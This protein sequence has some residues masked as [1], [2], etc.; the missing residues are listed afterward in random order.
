MIGAFLSYLGGRTEV[1]IGNNDGVVFTGIGAVGYRKRFDASAIKDVRIDD[2]QWRG[3]DGYRRRKECIV[4]ET[5][6]G[7]LVKLGSMLAEERRR[8]V[9]GAL[10]K[11]LWG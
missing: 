10:R 11:V 7:K 9:A 1:R 8:F 2:R 3:S 5:R 6:E 4:I